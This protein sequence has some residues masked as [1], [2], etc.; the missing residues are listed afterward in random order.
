MHS[1]QKQ[2]CKAFRVQ[3]SWTDANT[4]VQDIHQGSALHVESNIGKQNHFKA[5]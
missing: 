3:K 1:A 4:V 2:E 5:V